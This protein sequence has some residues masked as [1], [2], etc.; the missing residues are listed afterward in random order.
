MDQRRDGGAG[1][2]RQ[3]PSSQG[4]SPHAAG[5]VDDL[6]GE[7]GRLGDD[8]VGV[9]VVGQQPRDELVHGGLRVQPSA[10]LGQQRGQ[11][12]PFALGLVG[13]RRQVDAQAFLTAHQQRERLPAEPGVGVAGLGGAGDVVDQAGVRG[14][15]GTRLRL[16]LRVEVGGETADRTEECPGDRRAHPVERCDGRVDGVRPLLEVASAGLGEFLA[17]RVLAVVGGEFKVGQ[18]RIRVSAV[19]LKLAVLDLEGVLEDRKV[20]FVVRVGKGRFAE[21]GVGERGQSA[22]DAVGRQVL[23]LAVVLVE[24]RHLPD[25]RDHQ[26]AHGAKPI[27]HGIEGSDF[28][29]PAAIR[30]RA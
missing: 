9:R 6:L 7:P 19:Q 22:A 28:R 3:S 12:V 8:P 21:P 24:S 14:E 20:P 25:H 18:M 4:T 26:V 27:I 16:G 13:E 29:C 17:G 11:P 10:G 15:R 30:Q 1:P 23:H 5:E 2:T